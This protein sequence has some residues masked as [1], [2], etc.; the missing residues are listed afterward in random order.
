MIRVF[1]FWTLLSVLEVAYLILIGVWILLEKRSPVATLA[2]LLLLGALPVVGFVVFF[3]FGPRRLHRRRQRRIRSKKRSRAHVQALRA[4][5]LVSPLSIETEQLV[6]VANTKGDA[7]LTTCD[8]L[9]I[10][11]NPV[12]LYDR[13]EQSIDAATHHVHVLYYILEDGAAADRLKAALIRARARNVEVRVLVDA[14]GSSG[15]S[16][17]FF[18]ELTKAGG[19][20]ARFNPAAFSSLVKAF[21]FRNHRKIIVCDGVLGFTGGINMCDAYL[22]SKEEGARP[23]WRD[24]HL[25]LRGS[26]VRYL[27][28]AFMDDWAYAT[29]EILKGSVYLPSDSAL[30]AGAQ[31]AAEAQ[32]SETVPAEPRQVHLVQVIEDGPDSLDDPIHDAFF[33]AI[34]GAKQRVWLTTPYF[35]PDE[36]LATALTT[37]ALRG[38]DVQVLLPRRGDSRVVTYAARSYFDAMLAAGVKIFEY[39]PTMLHAKTAVIDDGIAIVGTANL[40]NRSLRLSFEV[41][42]FIYGAAQNAEL[43]RIFQEDLAHAPAVSLDER[44]RLPIPLKLA[45][46]GARLLSPIL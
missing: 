24:T 32:A 40:D 20:F 26:A 23:P 31:A 22:P 36:S 39:Q 14:V 25:L 38:V 41:V 33:T 37:A 28:L 35:I 2:W 30:S 16:R 19:Q 11:T 17:R 7:P 34:T 42:V 29:S 6:Q 44:A 8:E 12:A 1:V 43:A 45:E 21:N 3:M 9:E 46:A 4:S 10:M 18:R 15:L 27:Q 13:V 5:P